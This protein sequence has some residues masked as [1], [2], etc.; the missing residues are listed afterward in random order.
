MLEA[1]DAE[2]FDTK[3]NS[4]GEARAYYRIPYED[5]LDW[6]DTV[7]IKDLPIP[8]QAKVKVTIEADKKLAAYLKDTKGTRAKNAFATQ[9][10]YA[11]AWPFTVA[12]G[13][14]GAF[15]IE[16]LGW[17]PETVD[18]YLRAIP[19]KEKP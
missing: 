5:F 8:W 18:V 10:R 9:W 2:D 6:A 17:V 16:R 7:G 19:K 15:K 4:R 14:E 13:V 11:K 3:T 1:L 12:F